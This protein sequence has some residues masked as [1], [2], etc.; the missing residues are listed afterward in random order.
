MALSVI[1]ILGDVLSVTSVFKS[2][3][4]TGINPFWKLAFVFKCFTDTIIL[5]DFK[6]ALDKLKQYKQECQDISSVRSH[7]NTTYTR[8]DV[9]DVRDMPHERPWNESCGVTTVVKAK[10]KQ[11]EVILTTESELTHWVSLGVES[12]RRMS[13]NESGN[14]T[15]QSMYGEWTQ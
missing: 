10:H 7:E 3:L 15:H 4:P 12:S 6:T 8:R 9:A 14:S 1:F 11:K 13:G 2:S 5:D